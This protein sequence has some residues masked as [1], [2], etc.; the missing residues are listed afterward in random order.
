MLTDGTEALPRPC[1][2][3]VGQNK[4]ISSIAAPTMVTSAK[5]TKYKPI[6]GAPT[7]I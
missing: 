2:R 1:S 3:T 5:Q 6:G 4:V 7:T